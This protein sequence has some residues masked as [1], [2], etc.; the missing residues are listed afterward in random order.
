MLIMKGKAIYKWSV[1]DKHTG[2]TICGYATERGAL[3][4]AVAL[5]EKFNSPRRYIVKPR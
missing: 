1:V 3:N 4:G 2:R 5:C